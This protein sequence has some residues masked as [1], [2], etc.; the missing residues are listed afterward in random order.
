MEVKDEA[1]SSDELPLSKRCRVSKAEKRLLNFIDDIVKVKKSSQSPS[2]KARAEVRRLK[3]SPQ[4]IT[5][6]TRYPYLSNLAWLLEKHQFLQN[7]HLVLQDT[8]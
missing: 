3:K 5:N 6:H 4:Q 2:E 7:G 8:S 1:D